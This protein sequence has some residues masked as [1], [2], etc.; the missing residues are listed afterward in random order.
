MTHASTN[1]QCP[2]T[3]REAAA[4]YLRR[5]FIPVPIPPRSKKCLVD[6]WPNLRP[7]EADLDRLFRPGVESNVGLLLGEPSGGL[8][9]VDLD[10][11]ETVAA[12]PYLLP[13]TGR[14]SGRAGTAG[15]GL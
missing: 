7:T 12:A 2:S 1:G 14:V 3:A 6:D 13:T 4:Y 15:R 8:V 11:A 5:G 10:A 9:D